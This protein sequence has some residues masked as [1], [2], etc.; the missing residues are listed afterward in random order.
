MKSL[1]PARRRLVIGIMLLVLS[2]LGALHE[3]VVGHAWA[4]TLGYLFGQTGG[5]LVATAIFVVAVLFILPHGFFTGLFGWFTAGRDARVRT[6]V[7]VMDEH[8]RE[9]QRPIVVE[10]EDEELVPAER[11]RLD[12]VR[13]ALKGLGYKSSEYEKLVG[14]MDPRAPF[15]GLVK[16]ALKSLQARN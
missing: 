9:R 16:G 11:M 3:G 2:Y 12:D 4:R 14:A 5:A 13:T 1:H 15:E 10:E 6:V 8:V 7:R